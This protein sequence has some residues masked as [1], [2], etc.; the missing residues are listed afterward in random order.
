MFS[1]I[2]IHQRFSAFIK[3]SLSLKRL[4]TTAIH[5]TAIKFLDFYWS[6]IFNWLAGSVKQGS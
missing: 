2:A 1:C 3:W 4:R 6:I 5:H